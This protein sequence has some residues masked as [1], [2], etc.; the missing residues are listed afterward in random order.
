[1]AWIELSL[2]TTHEGLDWVQTL[3]ATVN[4]TDEIHL[5]R[6]V[7]TGVTGQ[8]EAKIS[9]DSGQSLSSSG[10]RLSDWAFTV[11]LYLPY[12][13]RVRMRV[14]EI[15]RQFAT[16]CRTGQTTPLRTDVVEQ[17]PEIEKEQG[18]TFH[19]IGEK[20]ILLPPHT[21]LTEIP[22]RIALK[23]TPSAAFGSGFH[24]ATTLCL[25]L[26]ERHVTPG[27][28]A[29]DLGSGSGIL[30]VAMAK[31]GA[32]V[33]AVDNDPVAVQATRGAVQEN[34]V[35]AA[36]TV[37]QGS[38][39]RGSSLGHWM[40]GSLQEPGET[41]GAIAQFDL[42]VANIL[43]RVHTALA[44][45]FRNA[46]R[47]TETHRGVLITGGFTTDYEAEVVAALREVGFETV[48]CERSHEWVAFA[49]RLCSASR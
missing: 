16:L 27:L 12:D 8:A 43:A 24:P 45:D 7:E 3:L 19:S 9:T 32:Q 1:M 4:Y 17:K 13:T 10:D 21:P 42:V 5:D 41:V 25:R 29:M 47:S 23:L 49:H 26:L 11:R 35:D 48:D 44:P 46:L 36:V 22:G 28:E 39:G 20:F 33:L 14:D 18:A 31:L 37:V 38:L 15:E 6:C 30:A 40:G 34:Q 2:D